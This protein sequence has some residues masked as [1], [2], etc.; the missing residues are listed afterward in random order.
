MKLFVYNDWVE[1]QDELAIELL[2]HL[3]FAYTNPSEAVSCRTLNT[4]QAYA[5]VDFSRGQL[6]DRFC[7]FLTENLRKFT[8]LE[9]LDLRNNS[10]IT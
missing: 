5:H 4:T 3:I 10:N 9:T 2:L 6:T 7:L 8:G 1:I